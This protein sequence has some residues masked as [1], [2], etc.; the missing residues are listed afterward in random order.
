MSTVYADIAKK[1]PSWIYK[2]LAQAYIDYDYPRHLFIETTATCNLACSYCPRPR[3]K[4]EMDFELFKGLIREASS[5]G[6]RSFSLHLFGEPLLYPR[7]RE[8]IDF[9]KRENNRHTV[10][11]TTNGTLIEKGEN[12]DL[13]IGSGVDQVLW[14]WRPEAAFKPETK[15]RLKQWGKF[16]VRIIKELTPK[17]ALEEWKNWPNQE[18]RSIHKYGGNIAIERYKTL[19][20]EMLS[21]VQESRYPCYHLWLA[22]GISWNGDIL[23][24]CSDPHKKEVL[25]KFP[26]QMVAQ[27]WN[28]E[29]I[30]NIRLSHL[31]GEYMG[32]CKDG[33][34]WKRY[35]SIF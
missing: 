6:A 25:G 32:I 21:Q 24:C 5:Y 7:W 23:I 19:H 33:D 13:L 8:A 30:K 10:L 15:K 17:E 11:L 14:S 28:G 20:G 3:I 9:I 1:L 18:K 2:P 22:P 34:V 26:E 16:R 31:R 27:C 12:L 29:Q 4:Q 35:A